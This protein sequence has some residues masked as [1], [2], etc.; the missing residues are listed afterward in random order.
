MSSQDTD[1]KE[2][3]IADPEQA[4]VNQLKLACVL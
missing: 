2:E 4:E 1:L 3:D